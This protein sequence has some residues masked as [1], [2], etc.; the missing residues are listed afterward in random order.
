MKSQVMKIY[1]VIFVSGD[2]CVDHPLNALGV[3]KR[4]LEDNGFSVGVIEKPDWT[5]NDDFLKLGKP[6]LFFGIT[7]GSV[8]SMLQNYTSLKKP[9]K[10][11]AYSPFDSKIPDRTVIVYA[12]KI[13]QL[14]KDSIMVI[15]GV[16]SSLRR[17]AHY[18]YW[19]NKLRKSILLDSRADILVY[20]AGEFPIVEIARRI[21]ENQNIEG[22][23]STCRLS[24]KIPQGFKILPSYED[25]VK[26]KTAFCKMQ[27]ML[28]NKDN[29]AQKFEN[30]YVLQYKAHNYTTNE[31]DCIYGLQYTRNIP[32]KA[33]KEF[34]KIQFSVVTHRGCIGKCNFCSITLLFGDKIVSRSEESILDEIRSLTKHPDFKGYIDDLGGPSANMYGMD[35]EMSNDCRNDCINCS[36]L[37]K[38]HSK[39]IQLLRKARAI[40]GIKKIFV[41]S[42]IR[43][44]LALE[45]QEYI[46]EI[47]LHH[48]SGCLKIAPEHFSKKVLDLMNKNNDRFYEFKNIF[49]KFNKKLNQSLRYYFMTAHPGS[50]I[51]DVK[52]LRK[53]I[54][55][56]SNTEKIQ[57]FI[58]TPMTVSTCMYYTSMNPQ[59]LK[60]I[61]VPYTY[62]EK[63]KQKNI[64]YNKKKR[65]E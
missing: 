51:D 9:R 7:S 45:S 31:L 25:V 41:R 26:D 11:D 29:L 52:L 42:G 20:G 58:P 13:K 64:L 35:C 37:R 62:N 30:R 16:E 21:K 61:Y 4:V 27:L 40:E 57:I 55:E 12:N 19:D 24:N 15:G 10:D 32:K 23:E 36:R 54:D 34:K 5:K 47:S 38:D 1:D 8:D 14:F 59:T 2:Y 50:E 46:K 49:D 6:R 65:I 43:Y 3:L 48:I 60:K 33:A 22:I 53:R 44:D 56:L 28:S 39:L 18:D 17:F 63:K